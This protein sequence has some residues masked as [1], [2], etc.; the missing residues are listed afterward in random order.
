[1][2]DKVFL[3]HRQR[4]ASVFEFGVILVY[5]ESVNDP[6]WFEV[7]FARFT[8]DLAFVYFYSTGSKMGKAVFVFVGQSQRLDCWCF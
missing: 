8:L 5:Y 6:I 7:V 2:Y 3:L 1:M 4:K